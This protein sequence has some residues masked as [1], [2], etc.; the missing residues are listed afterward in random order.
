MSGMYNETVVNVRIRT[1]VREIY[2]FPLPVQFYFINSLFCTEL[3]DMFTN[4]L[5]S[6]HCA[7]LSRIS[8][9]V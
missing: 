8:D 7:T 1:H 9:F 3:G 2:C 5:G 6:S 4:S